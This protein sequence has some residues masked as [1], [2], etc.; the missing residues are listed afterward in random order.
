M[1]WF[2]KLFGFREIS[3]AETQANFILEERTLSSRVSGRSW[4][5][6]E[7]EVGSLAELRRRFGEADIRRGKPRVSIVQGDVKK[8]HAMP[9]FA[10]ALFQV[11]SQ[12]NALEMIGPRIPPEKGVTRYEEDP[13]QGPACAVAAAPALVV[14]N[15]FAPF[16]DGV[17]Q[18]G[19]RQIDGLAD[20]GAALATAMGRDVSSLWKMRN[21]YALASQD[22]LE[23]IAAHLATL[24]EAGLDDLRGRLAVTIQRGV[25]VTA[26]GATSGHLVSQVFCS[27]LPVAYCDHDEESWEAFAVLV[28]EAAY[29]A[30][31]LEAAIGAARGGSNVVLL[32]L[33]GG[34]AFGNETDWIYRA[35]RRAVAVSATVDLDVRIVSYGCPADDLVRFVDGLAR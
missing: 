9:E 6:G 13:T 3:Y 27:A 20:F 34:G 21:G 33:L 12:F 14:R 8:L 17:G 1:D 16:P 28:L 5:V 22:G 24:D 23:A 35:I 32:T 29:E 30:T 31:L 2:E 10:G 11:A 25:E 18:T 4:S 19:D 7:L 15:Y 26:P